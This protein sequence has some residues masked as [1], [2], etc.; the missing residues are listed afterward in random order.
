MSAL[1]DI[2][3]QRLPADRPIVLGRDVGGPEE[4]LAVTTVDAF[5]PAV[6]DMRPAAHRLVADPRL[7]HRGRVD[8]AHPPR[9]AAP[10]G[11]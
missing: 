7:A 4:R 2:L 1:K 3:A 8:P 6:V 11:E 9:R 5:D 10:T